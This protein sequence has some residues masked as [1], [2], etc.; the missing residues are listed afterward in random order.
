M[1]NFKKA[2]QK[3]MGHEGGYVDD[4]DDRGGETYRGISRN[5]FEHWKGWRKIDKYKPVND[6]FRKKLAEDESLQKDV[7]DFYKKEFWSRFK[8]DEI[9]NQALAEELFDT[10]VNMG[11]RVAG[12]FLQQGLNLLNRNESLFEDLEEDGLIGSKS[13]ESLK[14]Y[15]KNDKPELLLKLLNI[16][17]GARYIDIMRNNPT[18]EKYARGWLNRVSIG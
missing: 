17:Q 16:L 11:W 2:F 9:S 7:R 18:Q 14:K 15:L 1:P 5:N 3:T 4:I 8:G 6:K 13:I 10:A 12:R